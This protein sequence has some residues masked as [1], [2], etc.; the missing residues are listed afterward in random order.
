MVLKNVRAFSQIKAESFSN[1]SIVLTFVSLRCREDGAVLPF[2]L[3]HATLDPVNVV[4]DLFHLHNISKLHNVNVSFA[5]LC[6]AH[7]YICCLFYSS[8]GVSV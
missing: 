1:R 2:D 3:L 8:L 6:D 5:L 7:F 4:S